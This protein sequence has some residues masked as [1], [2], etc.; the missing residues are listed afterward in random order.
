MLTH[1]K[2]LLLAMALLLSAGLTACGE[3]E[4][5]NHDNHGDD[6]TVVNVE[7]LNRDDDGA[8]AADTHG[9]HWH[10]SL[11]ALEVDGN[12]LSLG[13]RWLDENDDEVEIDYSHYSFSA[14]FESGADELIELVSHGDHLHL[15]PGDTAGTTAVVF[16]LL[17][18]DDPVYETPPL[19][20]TVA[21]DDHH[22]TNNNNHGHDHIHISELV[23][24]ERGTT[25][26]LADVHGN[27][28]HGSPLTISL[29]GELEVD[30]NFYD[31]D[32]QLIAL[33]GH[34]YSVGYR[35]ADGADETIVDV[36][37]HSD[38]LDIDGEAV[39]TTS[40]II[41]FL[42]DGDVEWEAPALGL[43]VVD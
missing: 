42:H 41:Q 31:E 37:A 35:Y 40:I 14:R 8:V 43:E 27:H 17:H 24:V 15:R 30:T 5:D 10:G 12:R 36:H 20:V 13:A 25:N 11:P 1:S 19:A 23:L 18:H 16:Q 26:E 29:G 22:N 28:W 32:G 21:G 33:D 3:E 39:G 34:H 2:P 38:H 9:D 6:P 4:G 7:L